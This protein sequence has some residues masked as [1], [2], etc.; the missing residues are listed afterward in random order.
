LNYSNSYTV[1]NAT[2]TFCGCVCDDMMLTVEDN[3]II[4]ARNACGLGKAWFAEHTIEERPFALVDGR[5]ATTAEG[6]EAAARI[7]AVARFPVIYGLSDTTCEAQRQAVAI[8]DLI[9]ANIDTTTSVCHGP[10][11]IAFQGVGESTATLGEIKN[12]ADLIVYWGG[13]PAESHPRHFTRYTLTPKGMFIPN[14]RKDRTVVLVDVRRTP[15][16]RAAD[17]FIQIKPRSDFEVLW[18]LR[19]LVK[20][21]AISPSIEDETGVPL[22]VLQDLAQRM[23]NCRYGV[24]FFGMGLTMTRGRHFNSGAVLALATDLNEFTH[25]VAKPVRG[26]GNVTGADNVLSWQT[27][28]PFAVNFSRGYPRFNPG[29]FT[30]V[31]LLARGEADAAL[32]IASDPAS[33]FPRAA[34]ERLGQIPTIV[35]DPK[36]TITTAKA[37]VAFTTATYGI[38]TAGTVYRMDDVP[39]TLRPAFP[40]PYPSDEEV[41]RAIRQRIGELANADGDGELLNQLEGQ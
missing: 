19:A 26:H 41:L 2:C 38:N 36:A 39:I 21:R 27:G 29:E 30:T 15:S 22:S 1:D 16:A 25:F 24:L 12:R 9:G 5:A 28:Y 23:K 10:S 35:L 14:G 4:Q 37:R 8:A 33:N 13:N 34:G 7:L 6:V 17:I 18:A 20:G 32:I 31:D 3:H 40:S 11:G